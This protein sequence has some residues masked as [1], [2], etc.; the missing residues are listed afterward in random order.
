MGVCGKIDIVANNVF[1]VRPREGRAR[2]RNCMDAKK[3][4]A[5]LGVACPMIPAVD[6]EPD[7]SGRRTRQ[8]IHPATAKG[9]GQA[10]SGRKMAHEGFVLSPSFT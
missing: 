6:D 4:G 8:T 7:V 9:V 10:K 2:E 3:K 5:L 1:F